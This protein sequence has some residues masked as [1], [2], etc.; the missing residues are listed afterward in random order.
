MNGSLCASS[1]DKEHKHPQMDIISED[2]HY[3]IRTIVWIGA[4]ALMGSL[5]EVSKVTGCTG[6]TVGEVS[7][8]KI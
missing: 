4:A 3:L 1:A 2:E 7:L 8:D 5:I 6:W